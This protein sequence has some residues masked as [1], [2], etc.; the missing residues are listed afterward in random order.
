MQQGSIQHGWNSRFSFSGYRRRSNEAQTAFIR[1]F[2]A[3]LPV[4]TVLALTGLSAYA[5]FA[6]FG[7]GWAQAAGASNWEAAVWPIA[8]TAV[9]TQALFCYVRFVPNMHASWARWL[10]AAVAA[11][12]M[13]LAALG[14][15]LRLDGSSS[16]LGPV[17]SSSVLAVPVL[18]LLLSAWMTSVFFFAIDP[19]ISEPRLPMRAEKDEEPDYPHFLDERA[20]DSEIN[21]QA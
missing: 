16:E 15:G 10:F 9:T 1:Q 20:A 19:V 3:G 4:R 5:A 7:I 14:N 12:G 6:N 13:V 8:V 11:A 17:A 18:C 21:K 2:V